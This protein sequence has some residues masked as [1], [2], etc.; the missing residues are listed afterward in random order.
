[1]AFFGGTFVYQSGR[2]ALN[3]LAAKVL[4]P[5]IFG[6][7]VLISLL[8][9]Y[10]TATGLGVT[11][12][13]GHQIPFHAGAGDLPT[14]KRMAST[15]A[16]ASLFGAAA[17]AALAVGL[18][19]LFLVDPQPTVLALAGAAAAL[20]HPFLLQQVLF[21]SW[22]AFER[23]AVQ[24]AGL[25][26]V[27]LLAGVALL[28]Y[29]LVGLLAAQIITYLA[30]AVAGLWLL[31]YRPWPVLDL[32]GSRVLAAIGFPIML[33]GLLY[34]LLTTIDRWLV[35]CFL[36]R[37]DV[38]YYGLVGIVLSGL[39]LI[40]QLL[41]QQFYPRMSFAW[42]GG[43]S[44]IELMKMAHRQGVIAGL[45]V[46]SF[47][48]LIVATAWLLVPSLL[49]AYKPSLI[50]LTIASVGV[51]AYAFGSGYGNLLNTVGAHRRFLS[52]QAIAVG[53]SVA[54]GVALLALGLGLPAVGGSSAA[55]MILYTVLA[56]RAATASAIHAS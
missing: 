34:G 1:M 6:E 36:T 28:R 7:W 25:G 21:R 55:G 44:R 54:L 26:G 32:R 20:Q 49:A 11:N 41:S 46:G 12:G 16:G 5:E 45:M 22:F 24:L 52:I 15:A 40:P 39:L 9:V 23:A 8:V 35:A 38:G 42:G 33:A 53:A 30:A 50:P 10:L 3:L 4:G 14:A 18:C 51:V 29:G 19:A 13:A 56:Y 37:E 27:V 48:I 47:T 2:L 43:S 31:P 17:A